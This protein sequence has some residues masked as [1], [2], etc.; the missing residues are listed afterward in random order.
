MLEGGLCSYC[1]SVSGHREY[2]IAAIW[3]HTAVIL[4]T[5][6][7]AWSV[8][9]NWT[10]KSSKSVLKND[11]FDLTQLVFNVLQTII[12]SKKGTLAYLLLKF[13]IRSGEKVRKSCRSWKQLQNEYLR[14]NIAFD[15]AENEYCEVWP[16]FLERSPSLA[17][18][19]F[20]AEFGHNT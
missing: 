13:W 11:E 9:Q 19:G 10:W 12:A 20:L 4:E 15:T 5:F 7:K 18:S 16:L 1:R 3:R 2:G 8:L 14:A 6:L 17:F